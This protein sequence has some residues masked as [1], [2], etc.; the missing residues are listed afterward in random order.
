MYF[1][2]QT[3]ASSVI[4]H[5]NVQVVNEIDCASIYS[6]DFVTHSTIC[7]SGRGGVGACI[8]DS[9]GPLILARS[10]GPILVSTVLQPGHVFVVS[11]LKVYDKDIK[12]I[13]IRFNRL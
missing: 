9:G 6:P 10:G 4:S 7:T 12:I 11:L 8:G 2:E 1:T 13:S 5:V 3:G